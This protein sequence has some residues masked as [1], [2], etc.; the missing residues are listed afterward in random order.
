[1][2]V[3]TIRDVAEAAGVSAMT[4][5]NVLNGRTA[6]ASAATVR[7][8]EE[9]VARLGY[10]PNGAARALS[11]K[12]SAIVALVYRAE[13]DATPRLANPHDSVF[14][15]EVERAVSRAGQHLMI[16]A[17]EDVVTTTRNLRTWNVDGAIFLGALAEQVA[18]LRQH[19]DV[20]M[21]FVDTYEPTTTSIGVDDRLG[22]RLAGAHLAGLGHRTHAFVGPDTTIGGV[23]Q[24][25][26]LGW[27]DALAAGGLDAG[28]MPVVRAQTTFEAGLDAADRLLA[29]PTLPTAVFCTA[30]VL[31][32]GVLKG[33][34]RAGVRVPRDVSVVG[35]DDT[36]ECRYVTP[37]LTTVGQDVRAKGHSAVELLHR[38]VAGDAATAPRT[39]LP[40]Q[41]VER[42]STA[43]PRA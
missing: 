31:A 25:R 19:A 17:A 6:R 4:V 26:F 37:A 38:L 21:V 2:A 20:P 7:A 34:A 35:F 42:E 43:P 23:V 30:D 33:L 36:P 13:Q 15:G 27:S 3:P 32:I 12:A 8:V 41:L 16:H 29:L 9:A 28:A 24:E 18:E 39:T 5:S 1:V 14:V 22:G 10:V 40:V 11:A